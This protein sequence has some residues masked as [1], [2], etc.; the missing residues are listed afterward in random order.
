MPSSEHYE[1]SVTPY[2]VSM[3]P[4][5]EWACNPHDT[6]QKSRYR[7]QKKKLWR[8]LPKITTHKVCGEGLNRFRRHG[9]RTTTTTD[10]WKATLPLQF[11]SSPNSSVETSVCNTSTAAGHMLGCCFWITVLFSAP[12][13][14]ARWLPTPTCSRTLHFLTGNG[15]RGLVEGILVLGKR[16]R[17]HPHPTN[18]LTNNSTPL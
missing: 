9:R 18:K 2:T 8:P 4:S 6:K 5:Q 11:S 1:P 16:R 15:T 3:W 12:S 13:S 14:Q 7:R 17:T 10:P